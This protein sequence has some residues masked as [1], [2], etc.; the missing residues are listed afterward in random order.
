[1]SC[2]CANGTLATNTNIVMGVANAGVFVQLPEYLA[3]GLLRF[4]DLPDNRWEVD[5]EADNVIGQ[6]FRTAP[7]A[8]LAVASRWLKRCRLRPGCSTCPSPFDEPRSHVAITC[9]EHPA[10]CASRLN[11]HAQSAR[12]RERP[13]SCRISSRKWVTEWVSRHVAEIKIK[14][15]VTYSWLAIR[16]SGPRTRHLRRSAES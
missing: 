4:S 6:S 10:L 15:S 16:F 11:T 3:E 12:V 5:S 8:H 14:N 13:C 7:V 1:M 2:D 9:A